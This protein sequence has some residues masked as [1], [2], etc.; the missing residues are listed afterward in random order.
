M[1]QFKNSISVT[2]S[3]SLLKAFAEE[4]K[5]IGYKC[6]YEDPNK[7]IEHVQKWNPHIWV[8]HND[9]CD[10][11]NSGEFTIADNRG[12]SI[13]TLLSL[14]SDWEKAIQLASEIKEEEFKVGDWIIGK[15]GMYPEKVKLIEEIE[16]N[17]LCYD[18]WNGCLKEHARKATKEEI[19][20]H[21]IEEAQKKG[22]VK[23]AKV[24]LIS[25][26]SRKCYSHNGYVLEDYEWYGVQRNR[27]IA[28]LKVSTDN[29][30]V[31]RLTCDGSLFT[32]IASFELLPSTPH[33]VKCNYKAEL[34]EWGLNFNNCAHFDKQMFIDLAKIFN[35]CYTYNNRAIESIKIGK[36]DFTAKEVIEIAEHFEGG[37]S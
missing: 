37:K 30:V 1:K 13:K 19:E 17:R 25:G 31:I 9:S 21:L 35:Y 22:F 28:E 34:P 12:S 4:L 26:K 10:V 29:T 33:I 11:F 7:R 18:E 5:V 24:N 20:N 23:G 32:D 3:Q 6:S 2:G 27:E 36:A 16:G 14:P 15:T 8:N